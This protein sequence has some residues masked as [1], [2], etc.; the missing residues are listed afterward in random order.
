MTELNQSKLRLNF[1]QPTKRNASQ[2]CVSNLPAIDGFDCFFFIFFDGFDCYVPKLRLFVLAEF[3][4]AKGYFKERSL[5][6]C[7]S[8]QTAT[9]L[10]RSM[11]KASALVKK[12]KK[13]PAKK[14]LDVKKTSTKQDPWPV[15]LS[16]KDEYSTIY[17]GPRKL[18]VDYS[19]R[20]NVTMFI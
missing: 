1:P 6:P 7:S 3:A 5:R 17:N 13:A 16:R 2:C 12:V 18:G 4:I 9:H 11:P 20:S 8:T 10:P 19:S 14:A 15:K